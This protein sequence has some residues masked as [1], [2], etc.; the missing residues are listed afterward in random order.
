MAAL[1]VASARRDGLTVSLAP[2]G[3]IALAGSKTI[4]E[5]WR[6]TLGEY[7]AELIETLK[8][9][10]EPIE[11]SLKDLEPFRFDLVEIEILR[12]ADAAELDRVNNLAFEI[13]QADRLPFAEAMRIAAEIT[14]STPPAECEAAYLNTR[15]TWN[16][17][18]LK[19]DLQ[20]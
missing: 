2:S 13:I 19:K 4:I 18:T 3:T 12:G 14:V 16:A 9:A 10:N 17:L 1:I 5:R 6:P 7:R 11:A 20:K 15:R 8:A